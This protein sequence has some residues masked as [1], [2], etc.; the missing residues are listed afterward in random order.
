MKKIVFIIMTVFIGNLFANN[1]SCRENLKID[2]EFLKNDKYNKEVYLLIDESTYFSKKDKED[3]I[4]KVSPFITQNTRINIDSFSE[5][6]RTRKNKDLGTFYIYSDMTEDE[7]DDISRSKV[8][9]LEHCLNEAKKYAYKGI[10]KALDEGVRKKGTNLKKSEILKNLKVYSKNNIRFS[11]AKRKIV[12]ILSDMLENSDYT[13]F[14][15][16]GKLKKLDINKELSI[17]KKHRLFGK[18]ADAEIYVY[19]MGLIEVNSDKKEA[20]N[21]FIMDNLIEFW[22]EYFIES[23]GKPI[24]LD[25]SI[26][27]FDL[28]Y[29]GSN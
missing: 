4:K 24:G 13:S 5:Y 16:N 29:K 10:Q 28:D 6:S 21:A 27:N 17:A 1:W 23:G 25:S 26:M 9:K 19:G 12:I 20:R 15:K 7:E 2:E 14:Y 22:D 11:K 18:F 3:I 8:R